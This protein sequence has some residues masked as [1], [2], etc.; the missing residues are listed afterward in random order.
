MSKL[1]LAS[2]L[3]GAALLLAAGF[4][5]VGWAVEE[6]V[7][8]F[9]LVESLSAA[10]ATL[11]D[12][13][14]KGSVVYV[15]VNPGPLGG[16][17]NANIE[18]NAGNNIS[19]VVN[20][21]GLFPDDEASD[22]Y[23][24]GRFTL[25]DGETFTDDDNDI[26]GL[27]DGETATIE[28]DLDG[29]TD[30][31]THQ[32]TADYSPPDHTKP[33][34]D[35]F[36]INP[37]A[38]S[39]NGDQIQDTTTI[40]YTL[41][42]NISTQVTVR[43][44][45][46]TTTDVI[47]KTLVDATTQNTEKAYSCIWDGTSDAGNPVSD[48]T[49]L[50]RILA[51][52]G[53][54]NSVEE[55]L[56]VTIDTYPPIISGVSASPTPFSPNNDAVKDTTT[57]SF[58]LSGATV[59]NNR[60]EIR[61]CSGILVRTL[62]DEISP[63][64]GAS[65]GQNQVIWD[66]KDW[67]GTV[68]PDGSY[69]YEII[70]VDDAGN[71]SSFTGQII[72][73][74][75]PPT[76]SLQVL[77]NSGTHSSPFD[78]SDLGATPPTGLYI[79]DVQQNGEWQT[80]DPSGVSEV[81]IYINGDLFSPQNPNGNWQGWYL[82]WTP[83][84]SDDTYD[85][86]VRA[87]D[88][89]GNDTSA[90]GATTSIIY[91]NQSPVAEII[92]P[93]DG[94]KFN[95]STLLISGQATDTT[96]GSGVSEVQIQVTNLSTS[97]VIISF[98]TAAVVDTSGQGDWSS[99]EYTFDPPDSGSPAISYK[100]EC[101]AV[102]NLYDPLSPTSSSHIQLSPD[103][104]T[105]TY[106]TQN[107]PYHPTNLKDDGVSLS[108][109]HIFG[110]SNV[111]TCD[112][113]NFPG[114]E[115][116]RFEYRIEPSGSWQIIG[117]HPSPGTSYTPTVV[118][119][120]SGLSTDVTYSFR[121]V[122]VGSEIP[123]GVFSEC[124]ID[125]TAPSAPY[126]LSDDGVPVT[127][128]HI[129][130]RINVLSAEADLSDTSL[131][132]VRF[133]YRDDTLGGSWTSIDMDT[134][135]QGNTFSTTWDTSGLDPEHIYSVRA[136][137]VDVAGNETSSTEFT[138]CTIQ[139][140]APVFQS[141]ESDKTAYKNEDTVIITANLDNSG[142]SLS[143]DFSSL[144]SEYGE[145]NNLESVEDNGDSTY[146]I[147]Y[148]ISAYNTREDASCTLV[149]IAEDSTANTA[150][151]SLTVSLD[152]T[153]PTAS[154]TSPTSGSSLSGTCNFIVY[155]SQ[156]IDSDVNIFSLEYRSTGTS[157]W[158]TCPGQVQGEWIPG[159]N[160]TISFDTTTC[161]DGTYDFRVS[162]EDEAG[163]TGLTD[164]V[165]SITLDNGAPPVPTG[166]E[167][168]PLPQ[169]KVKLTWEASS[170]EDDV[171]WYNVYRSTTPYTYT[172]T[173]VGQ[174]VRGTYPLQ[175]I[176]GPLSDATTYYFYVT[177]EDASGNESLPSNIDSATADS[178]CPVFESSIQA[179]KA[180]YKDG[181][182]ISL[183]CNLDAAGYSL[184]CDFSPLDSE[185]GQG[186][187]VESF[188]DF[189]DSTYE[190][191][192]TISPYNQ[193]AD[194]SY[195]VIVTA[196]DE[197]GN[198]A[199]SEI[200]LILDN[201]PPEFTLPTTSDKSVY[202]NKDTITLTC[203]LDAPGYTIRCSFDSIDTTYTQGAEEVED[204]G[205]GSYKVSYTIG[206]QN[207]RED[208][209]YSVNLSAEDIAGNKVYDSIQLLLDN[210]PPQ[211]LE[212]VKVGRFSDDNLNN[213]VDEE[214]VSWGANYFKNGDIV[215]LQIHLEGEDYA[216]SGQIQAN[217][218]S[219]D[220]K[221]SK[222]DEQAA[223][224]GDGS[225]SGGGALNLKDNLDNNQ[226]GEI[227]DSEE[228]YYYLIAYRIKEDNQRNDSIY[229]VPIIA[230]DEAGN[231]TLSGDNSPS[232]KL[233]NTP[234]AV[235]NIFLTL[236]SKPGE[237]QPLNTTT[238]IKE[239]IT[240]LN[241]TFC[242]G[243]GSGVNIFGSDVV[244]LDPENEIIQAETT[245][246]QDNEI[247]LEW[248]LS[249]LP[250]GVEGYY[251]IRIQVE[252]LAGNTADYIDYGFIYDLKAPYL[253]SID[254]ADLATLTQPLTSITCIIS[255]DTSV[256]SQVAGVDIRNCQITLKDENGQV[257]ASGGDPVN[258]ST[259]RLTSEEGGYLAL[260]SGIYS[261]VVKSVDFAGNTRLQITKFYLEIDPVE[262]VQIASLH[263]QGE[264]VYDLV[265]S[266]QPA[267]PSVFASS[268]VDT[269]YLK[270]KLSE[271]INL[272]DD[273]TQISLNKVTKLYTDRV[274]TEPVEGSSWINYDEMEGWVELYFYIA[275]PFNP[276]VD[277]HTKDGFYQVKA[278]IVDEAENSKELAF[279]FVFD[280]VPPESP[281]F[282]LDSFD[283][284]TQVVTLSGTTS[285]ESSEPQWIQAFVNNSLKATTQANSDR[286]FTVQFQ[287][288]EG[289]NIITLRPV[290]RAGNVGQFTS[291]LKLTYN[292]E[293]LLV[294]TFRSSRL[295]R[296]TAG[297]SPVKLVYYLSESARVNI[298]IYNL[299]GEIVYQWEDEVSPGSEQEWSWWGENMY[300]KKV[301]NGIYIMVITATS[302]TR[303]ESVTKLVGVL[304]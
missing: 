21:Q 83:P 128:G 204:K 207:T 203:Y 276:Q 144:D 178:V 43:L 229:T 122:A 299:L 181:D 297:T 81:R 74:T 117:S 246:R 42:D 9:G 215:L 217:F 129:F 131:L 274:E 266:T 192:Y 194:S 146:T 94:I 76:T 257:L 155:D 58:S 88:T 190:I 87:K 36:A 69:F 89:V 268:P 301:N 272:N 140:G 245:A 241:L 85:I 198:S 97:T 15:R 124:Q 219:L 130:G 92:S 171:A 84:A 45:I 258:A 54:G 65:N 247:T 267:S 195:T 106:D 303:E 284:T 64:P 66:G 107:P 175:F 11:T 141:I 279:Y 221:Y 127:N 91:D 95:T 162:L 280:T 16:T 300:G 294:I 227:N 291:S 24:W 62:V 172:F 143:C 79:S 17:G 50:C 6:T 56:G 133:E 223:I 18:E 72:V 240:S 286:S 281:Q 302:S 167:A 201:F 157:S 169:A 73:D 290:D 234:P 136:T 187:N 118:W 200:T 259:L 220:S 277:E 1:K 114:L 189:E 166:L 59:G 14:N 67:T 251:T 161:G 61:D 288:E 164:P 197:A 186:S 63:T 228:A 273:A 120:T 255:E 156:V 174:V 214:E 193:R 235:D 2:G 135:P 206:E 108:T 37:N 145:G 264:I 34:V 31:G 283:S 103:S 30:P 154:I 165:Y 22:G 208:G 78:L 196:C 287:L 35:N 180:Y 185:Y 254:P 159:A 101:R 47:V 293:R 48:G 57:I 237:P 116:V 28:C 25:K 3:M 152:N 296:E 46:R 75:T 104:I 7:V 19:I 38:F 260:T 132:G 39:P 242:D 138:G 163:N 282:K 256:T 226:D 263:H 278:E 153:L 231:S 225:Q 33:S 29:G 93:S 292:S 109:G 213:M 202:K 238:A 261:I 142:Y 304:R 4:S 137:S 26:L 52:D 269:I 119:N 265:S 160:S 102:D 139:F 222:G 111:L 170:P 248:S 123:S 115:E 158:S 199:T 173:Q 289:E 298:R 8:T 262:T 148:T 151:S 5:G 125:N 32:I 53:S 77:D 239:Q 20:D 249:Q 55:T 44:E 184:S 233:D 191:N 252:D 168:S 82:Y 96:E 224:P 121:A 183:F 270:V 12:T 275:S 216:S 70:S 13:F 150:S 40:S 112:Q 113:E 188:Q 236:I 134:F 230:I 232:C 177:S 182:T 250:L 99:W 218:L 212:P 205:D 41:S 271:S 210:T 71:T 209:S 100:I 285:P 179:D 68:V 243:D 147:C 27:N 176:D 49:Y 51:L 126:N 98:T 86:L 244:L 80:S 149:I 10:S 23:Y 211:F 105:I 90:S 110:I 253:V 60:V 295:L